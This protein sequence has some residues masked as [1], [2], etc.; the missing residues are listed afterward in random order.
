MPKRNSKRNN[1]K[2]SVDRVGPASLPY[3]DVTTDKLTTVASTY[4]NT[5]AYAFK[6]LLPS[7]Q[8]GVPRLVRFRKFKIQFGPSEIS[9]GTIQ[10]P[11]GVQLAALDVVTNQILPVTSMQTLSEVNPRTMSFTLPPEFSRWYETS[12]TVTPLYINV[13]NINGASVT[14]FFSVRIEAFA[15]VQIPDPTPI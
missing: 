4:S 9:S 14:S 11:V 10:E 15:N 1:N 2:M 5:Y 7:L 13:Y 6:Q 8:A 3:M 12:S